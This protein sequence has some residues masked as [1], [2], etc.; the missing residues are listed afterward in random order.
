[1]AATF[2]EPAPADVPLLTEGAGEDII[3]VKDD[4]MYARFFKMLSVGI[5]APQIQQKMGLEGLDPEVI[6]YVDEWVVTLTSL[7]IMYR[8][9]TNV[10]FVFVCLV[11]ILLPRR[12][13]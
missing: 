6:L 10:C 12:R 13:M 7:L 9:L 5:P 3:A 2:S 1:M 8:Y 4:P 11:W